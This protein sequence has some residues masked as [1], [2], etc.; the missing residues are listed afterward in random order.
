VKQ[1]CFAIDTKAG[2]WPMVATWQSIEPIS[3]PQIRSLAAYWTAKSAGRRAPAR[4]DIDPQDLRRCLPNLFML[5]VIE[6]DKRFKVRLVGT[7]IVA[8]VGEDHTGRFLDETIPADGY[9]ALRQEIEDVV[10]HFVFRYRVNA[11]ACQNRSYAQYHGLML[12]LSDDQEHVN[13]VLGIGYVIRSTEAEFPA[14]PIQAAIQV[15]PA[16]AAAAK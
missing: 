4:R 6:P 11:L 5:D 8:L 16:H 1:V 13:I 3:H 14:K 15:L 10:S 7:E 2:E 9:S 12:P